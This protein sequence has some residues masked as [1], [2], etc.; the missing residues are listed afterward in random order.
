MTIT[1]TQIEFLKGAYAGMREANCLRSFFSIGRESLKAEWFSARGILEKFDVDYRAF[2]KSFFET[3][4]QHSITMFE[5]IYIEMFATAILEEINE[6]SE[7]EKSVIYTTAKKIVNGNEIL[8][9]VQGVNLKPVVQGVRV[10]EDVKTEEKTSFDEA[11]ELHEQVEQTITAQPEKVEMKKESAT[12]S[13]NLMLPLTDIINGAVTDY[14]EN[15]SGLLAHVDKRIE[16]EAQ[17]LRPTVIK[18][19]ERATVTMTG[20]LHKDFEDVLDAAVTERQVY[21]AGAAGTGKT[22]LAG[23]V[24]KAMGLRFSHISCTAGMSEAHLLGRMDAHGNYISSDLVDLYENGGVFLFDEV[25]AADS[26]TMLVINSAL[27][28]GHMSVPNRKENRVAKRH[29]DFICICAANTW[30]YGSN[31]YAGRNILD[32]AFLDR[33][34]LS[35][36]EI[37]YDI[38]LEYEISKDFPEVAETIQKIRA[39][40]TK[41]R[42]RRVVSTRAIIS[43][44]RARMKGK[45]LKDVLNRFFTGWTDEE[46]KKAT[47]G[48]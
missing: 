38:K 37:S 24:A 1:N 47:E 46:R 17:K 2:F 44:V 42:I 19:G 41:N 7:L 15:K 11:V 32:Q 29:A 10:T 16:A 20:T 25:D 30:G 48:I 39:N 35:K 21:L 9:S 23:Q 5:P 34:T 31:E 3:E 12:A 28:N 33:F 43:G 40:V 6:R 22:T 26:N 4:G 14:I 13:F 8:A 36:F 45:S 27:T 18:I